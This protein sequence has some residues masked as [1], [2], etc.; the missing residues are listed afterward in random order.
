MELDHLIESLR[1]SL[2]GQPWHGPSLVALLAD[3]TPE[4][5]ATH[6]VAGAH[7]ILELVLHLAAWQQEVASRLRGNP[8]GLPAL[9]DWPLPAGDPATAWARARRLLDEAHAD[10]LQLVPGLSAGRLDQRVGEAQDPSLGTDV[11]FAVM[12]IGLAQH[13][14]YHGGQIAILERALAAQRAGRTG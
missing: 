3:V 13:D 4:G 7:S 6:P 11:P 12:L 5:A 10:L 2:S 14:A 9:G 1:Q 8:P